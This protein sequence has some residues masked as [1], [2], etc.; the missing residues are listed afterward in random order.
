TSSTAAVVASP[1]D[2]GLGTALT[3]NPQQVGWN[4]AE[5]VVRD[6]GKVDV[7][8]I[9]VGTLPTNTTTH[10]P[11]AAY[12]NWTTVSAGYH[13]EYALG[14]TVVFQRGYHLGWQ[15]G[16]NLVYERAYHTAPQVG[17]NV[18]FEKGFHYVYARNNNV[19]F[20]RSTSSKLLYQKWNGSTWTSSNATTYFTG[21]PHNT[22]PDSSDNFRTQITGSLGNNWDSTNAPV[23]NQTLYDGTNTTPDGSDGFQTA[24]NGSLSSNWTAVTQAQYDG[25]NTTTDSSDGWRVTK[26]YSTPFDQWETSTQS[27]FLSGNS[28]NTEADGWR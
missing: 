3:R 21:T 4:R 26:V 16:N 13:W 18:T 28:N 9:F 10:Q 27:A 20:Q 25:S 14:N 17:N 19:V 2:A 22:T 1:L 11:T 6:R 12:E 8:G 15:R 5:R 7:I 24:V 23:L